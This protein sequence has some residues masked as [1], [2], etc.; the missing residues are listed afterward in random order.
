[1]GCKCCY[2]RKNKNQKN[3]NSLKNITNINNNAISITPKNSIKEEMNK[4]IEQ[5]SEIYL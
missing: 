3:I 4:S 5:A 1:M 2:K